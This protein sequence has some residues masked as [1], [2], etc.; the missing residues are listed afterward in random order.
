MAGKKITSDIVKTIGEDV[1]S[2]I[3][4][5]QPTKRNARYLPQTNPGDNTRYLH[6]AMKIYDLGRSPLD[7]HS[8]EE[9]RCR[10]ETYFN[11]CMAND[12]KPSVAGLA[13]A[14]GITRQRL[15]QRANGLGNKPLEQE[16]IE[17]YERAYMLLNAQMEDYMQNGKINPV[18]G[19]FLMKNNMGYQD[20]Q[21]YIITPQ[22]GAERSAEEL[23]AEADKLPDSDE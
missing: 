6:N 11:I 2:D 18:S 20:Q 14:F 12:M 3:I 5:K 19:I 9:T 7:I 13:L 23:I 1:I 8:A 17:E 16:V 21:E 10:I 4:P 22:T 15:W